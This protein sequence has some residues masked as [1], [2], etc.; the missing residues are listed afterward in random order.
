[1]P[2][3]KITSKIKN[4][5]QSLNKFVKQH[6][7]QKQTRLL[8][9]SMEKNL[10]L[11]AELLKADTDMVIGRVNITGN[12]KLGIVYIRGMT[13]K[14]ALNKY[15]IEPLMNG[16]NKFEK[17]NE[18]PSINR[19]RFIQGLLKTVDVKET[20]QMEAVITAV[21]YGNVCLFID[22]TDSALV[23]GNIKFD[24]RSIE[25]PETD[26]VIR[27]SREGFI[28][29]ISTNVSMVRR[30]LCSPTLRFE[31]FFLGKISRTEIRLS[32]IE[33]IANPKI[34]EEVRTRIQRIDIDYIYGSGLIAELIEDN[35]SSLWP[36]VHMSERPDVVAAN[37]AEGR[38]AIFCNGF[39]YIII[40]P[41]LFWQ[42]LQTPDDYA[43]KPLIGSF[44][45]LLR[46]MAFYIS[47]MMSPIF[48]A[49]VSFHPTIIPQLLA[50]KIAAGREGVP[51]P[52]IFEALML[53]LMI[54]LLREAGA[55][56]PK[57]IGVAV[58]VLGAVIIGQA[59]VAAGFVS[60][61]VIIIV[62]IAAIANF[63]IPSLELA[64]ATRIAN[65]LLIILGGIF[66]LLGVTIGMAWLL[67]TVISLRSFGIPLF[68]PLAPGEN[69]GL[70]DI[71]FRAP[72]WQLRKRPSL[73]AQDNIK[74]MG[75]GTVKP[76]PKD[77][78]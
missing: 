21:L 7:S 61:T 65:Y 56:L 72:V 51:V 36:Q 41:L 15:V 10:S 58:A 53:T 39:P 9:S 69:Y 52:S 20:K 18:T 78:G 40:A 38:F 62:A 42:N 11:I 44:F 24:K 34:I 46:H 5:G 55:R 68:Y 22:G 49:L 13:D 31:T 77:R 59:A 32:W 54:D 64:N 28:E 74:K 45:R 14:D 66:G 30:R 67:W 3:S 43:D 29:D 48:V 12:E 2:F 71:F 26:T 75:A 73:L 25:N 23:V 57:P 1:M 17:L 76:K 27:G 35:P 50:F 33:G 37:L 19:I 8:T 4:K 70:K 16:P 60:P 47:L 6:P 63:S